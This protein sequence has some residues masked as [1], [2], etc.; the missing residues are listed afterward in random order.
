M[1]V[2]KTF[3]L[4]ILEK[5]LIVKIGSQNFGYCCK[6]HPDNVSAFIALKN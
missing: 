6:E 4:I 1:N 2:N 3:Y 5:T